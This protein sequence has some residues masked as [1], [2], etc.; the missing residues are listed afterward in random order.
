MAGCRARRR[1]VARRPGPGLRPARGRGRFVRLDEARSR[2]DGGSGLGL[3]I[4]DEIVRAHGGAVLIAESPLGGTHV[5]IT[6][7]LGSGNA[8]QA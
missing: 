4:V 8:A 5:E 6:F 2:D 1:R 7:R 3:A